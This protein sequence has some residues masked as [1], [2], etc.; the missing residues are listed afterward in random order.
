MADLNDLMQAAY[1]GAGWLLEHQR[2]D[3]SFEAD[4]LS[5]YKVPYALDITGHAMQAARTLD[6]IARTGFTENGVLDQKDRSGVHP[7]LL[8][9]DIYPSY[10]VAMG[11]Q[12]LGRFDVSYR[13]HRII[14]ERYWDPGTGGIFFN[15]HGGPNGNEV[16]TLNCGFGGLVCLYL[17]DV[18]T[19]CASARC[20]HHILGIQDEPSTFWAAITQH[21][22]L[23][24]D[25]GEGDILWRRIDKTSEG[26]CYF[27]AGHA[28]GFLSLLYMATG[29]K[30][31]LEAA[32]GYRNVIETSAGDRRSHTSTGKYGF[33]A[34]QLYRATGDPR[35]RQAA[36]EV[37]EFLMSI[38]APEG[39]WVFPGTQYVG[40]D[41]IAVDLTA[42]FVAW[43]A[44]IA[45]G[46]A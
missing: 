13:L 30:Q 29:E 33:G 1:R 42:E 12:R 17:G 3:G 2:E 38:Q 32:D 10:W 19:A 41:A 36:I 39:Y 40:P 5:A 44:E 46:V 45:V 23:D 31:W 43:L 9:M 22:Q 18:E 14:R 35:A 21:G 16:D 7:F 34:A 6:W 24:K 11:A 25:P 15:L 8:M 27:L 37:G 4:V 20:L 28:V 26:Q